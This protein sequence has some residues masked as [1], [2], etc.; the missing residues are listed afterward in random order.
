MRTALQAWTI[1]T[2]TGL[3]GASGGFLI[4]PALTIQG[5]LPLKVAMGTSLLIM[6]MNSSLGFLG[7]MVLGQV[8]SWPFLLIL[9]TLAILGILVGA[10]YRS[11]VSE[12]K[13]RSAF[14]GLIL[15]MGT[16]ILM[17][18]FREL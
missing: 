11:K 12:Q 8:V 4:I 18:Q 5:R 13:L 1:G 10:Q 9:V 3:V 14:A 17:A 7:D 16:G 15:L 6:G 2:V